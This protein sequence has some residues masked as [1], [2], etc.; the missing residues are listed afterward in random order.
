VSRNVLPAPIIF[1]S[2]T[3]VALVLT[4]A[5]ALADSI[6]FAQKFEGR[7]RKHDADEY[8]AKKAAERRAPSR[9]GRLCRHEETAAWRAFGD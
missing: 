1:E 8:M 5:H 4:L 7:K 2:R 9:A 6:A 3:A